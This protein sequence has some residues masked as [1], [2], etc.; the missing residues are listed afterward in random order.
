MACQA[1]VDRGD[2]QQGEQH[3]DAAAALGRRVH[4]V[5]GGRGGT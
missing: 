2:G 5:G 1:I 3:I 4:P